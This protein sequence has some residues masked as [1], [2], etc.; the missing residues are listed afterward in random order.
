MI[1]AH[2]DLIAHETLA[3]SATLVDP[4]SEGLPGTVGGGEEILVHALRA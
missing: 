3:I 2:R 4:L 1:S